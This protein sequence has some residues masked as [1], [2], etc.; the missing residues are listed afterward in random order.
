MADAILTAER[1]RELV[2]YDPETGVFTRI[3]N[4]YRHP[5]RLGP[6]PCNPYG[7]GYVYI[8]LDG[9]R[10]LAHRVAWLYVHGTWPEGDTDH[11]NGDRTDNRLSNLRAVSREVNNQNRRKVRANNKCGLMGV[12][13]HTHSRCWRARIMIRGRE[14]PLGHFESKEQAYAAYID[15][16]RSLHAGCTI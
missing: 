15:A 1:L 16:K 4:V 11:I 2:S 9:K 3:K 7:N 12:S 14:I 5:N 13:W 8:S 10:Y 6:I